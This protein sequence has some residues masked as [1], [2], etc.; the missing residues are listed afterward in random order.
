MSVPLPIYPFNTQA[1]SL[2]EAQTEFW[3]T[4]TLT[5]DKKDRIST[6]EM[7]M[8]RK[9]CFSWKLGSF[10]GKYSSNKQQCSDVQAVM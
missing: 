7:I 5:M 1:P 8:D 4:A 2:K 3:L 10:S 9:Y 6:K